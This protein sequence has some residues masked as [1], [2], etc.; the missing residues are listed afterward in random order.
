MF[1]HSFRSSEVTTI[2]GTVDANKKLSCG[3]KIKKHFLVGVRVGSGT[4]RRLDSLC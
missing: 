1:A 3:G 4:E 2:L